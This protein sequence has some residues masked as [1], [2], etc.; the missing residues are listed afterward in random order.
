M[1]NGI[2]PR[3]IRFHISDAPV[4][5]WCGGDPAMTAIVDVFSVFL[6]DGERFFIRSLK[7][8]RR[9]VNDPSLLKAIE[10][11][12]RQEAYHSREHE[13]YNRAIASLGY[14]VEAMAAEGAA[15]L[16][17]PQ[18]R[19]VSLYVTCAIEHL[20]T[21]F[22][23]V[24]LKHPEMFAEAPA[25][26]R[27]LWIWH[28]LEEVEHRAVALDVLKAATPELAGWRR[29]RDRVGIYL[30]ALC[31]LGRA[32]RRNLARYAEAD[33]QKAGL[34]FWAACLRA[35]FFRPGFLR[36]A[37]P[38]LIAYLKPGFDPA[39]TH[40]PAFVDAWRSQVADENPAA[41]LT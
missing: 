3:N 35:C 41:G 2:E 10:D 6:P 34:R 17:R 14:D 8:M 40:D 9:A 1:N 26:Y 28:A 20:T 22:A 29:Y 7:R 32:W 24:F 18:R 37:L 39:A 23:T 30:A 21:T 38:S 33:G 25:H 5:H 16:A 15:A 13:D 11:F 19:L 4:R 31:L 12:S 36:Y 27:R